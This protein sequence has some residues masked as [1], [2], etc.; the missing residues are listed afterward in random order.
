MVLLLLAPYYACLC[1]HRAALQ[2][3]AIQIHLWHY[4]TRRFVAS[5]CFRLLYSASETSSPKRGPGILRTPSHPRHRQRKGFY[6]PRGKEQK[7]TITPILLNICLTHTT[8]SR[9][10]KRPSAVHSALVFQLRPSATR[11]AMQLLSKSPDVHHLV[12]SRT[13]SKWTGNSSQW[14]RCPRGAICCM[15][16]GLRQKGQIVRPWVGQSAKH[17]VRLNQDLQL[18]RS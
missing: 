5:C 3:V 14:H 13:V 6:S 1:R 10:H 8:S 2:V 12:I 11:H 9:R 17:Q 7:V 15:A 18:P 4:E 16:V